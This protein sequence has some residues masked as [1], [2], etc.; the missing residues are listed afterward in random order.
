MLVSKAHWADDDDLSILDR[1]Q[2]HFTEIILE[3]VPNSVQ[4]LGVMMRP[5]IEQIANAAGRARS[6]SFGP[7]GEYLHMFR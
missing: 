6:S 1:D 4:E 2:L 7:N 3:T 5:L